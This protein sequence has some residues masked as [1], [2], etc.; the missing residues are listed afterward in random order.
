MPDRATTALMTWAARSSGRTDANAPACRPTGVRRAAMIA[1]RL[2]ISLGKLVHRVLLARISQLDDDAD[3]L[4]VETLEAAFALQVFQ[5]TSDRP[6]AAKLL[7]LLVCEEPSRPQPGNPFWPHGPA[8]ALGERLLE[9]REIGK[10]RHRLD[11]GRGELL[12]EALVIK[13]A[14]Q[15]MHSRVE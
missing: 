2:C 13:P 6:F 1:G 4:L 12:A 11:M 8:L 9:E 10:R 3:R 14:L 7:R 5:V 15:V